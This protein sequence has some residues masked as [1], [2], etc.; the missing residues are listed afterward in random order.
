MLIAFG[1]C[2]SGQ[3]SLTQAPSTPFASKPRSWGGWVG[4]R[5]A[6]WQVAGRRGAGSWGGR[7]LGKAPGPLPWLAPPQTPRLPLSPVIWVSG[8]ILGC[9]P[10]SFLA[11]SSPLPDWVSLSPV[12]VEQTRPAH[13]GVFPPTPGPQA[14]CLGLPILSPSQQGQHNL[15][16]P[17]QNRKY[18]IPCSKIITDLKVAATEP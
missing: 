11:T 16:I 18:K 2:F 4:H 15:Q 1:F 13:W 5:V 3:P 7:F 6:V 17:V 9:P 14:P 12:R 8:A 10:I